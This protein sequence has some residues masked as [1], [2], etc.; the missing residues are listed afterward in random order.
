MNE[1]LHEELA[2]CVPLGIP[3]SRFLSWDELDQ[4]KA[5]AYMREQRK[6][7]ECGTRREE[8]E[9][10]RFAYVAMPYHCPGC[11]LIEIEKRNLPDNAPPGIKIPL[12]P[13]WMAEA[14]MEQES[15]ASA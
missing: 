4:D 5:L 7:C 15:R 8:W 10:D 2:Y 13:R 1:R 3:H 12:V 11:E 14:M 6:I 9:R